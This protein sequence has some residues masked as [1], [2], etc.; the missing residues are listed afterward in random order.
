MAMTKRERTY[1][2]VLLAACAVFG[3][4]RLALTPYL[5]YR[6]SLVEARRTKDAALAEGRQTL[7][8]AR[9]LRVKLA[10]MDRSL[11]AE[12]S[13]AE[14]QLLRLLQEAEQQ[15]GVSGASFQRTN[16]IEE[17]GFTRLAFQVTATGRMPAVA[18]LMYRLETAPIPLRVDDA[19]FHPKQENGDELQIH[20]TVS[21][22]CRANR[23]AG[24]R[25]ESAPPSVAL[26]P[27]T[28]AAQ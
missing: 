1:G 17:H 2:A 9:R 3:L 21:T 4:D 24:P 22:L 7:R 15:T 27:N 14:G 26:S 12:P 13:A 16:T 20:L 6:N 23:P 5:D 8:D 11:G 28:G 18:L 19:Q 10:G 25:E